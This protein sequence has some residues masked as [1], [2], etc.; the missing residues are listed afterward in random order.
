M[1]GSTHEGFRQITLWFT[2]GFVLGPLQFQSTGQNTHKNSNFVC[3]VLFIWH[4]SHWNSTHLYSNQPT[5]CPVS[6]SSTHPLQNYVFFF[7]PV[8]LQANKVAPKYLQTYSLSFPLEWSQVTQIPASIK[9]GWVYKPEK[10]AFY[11]TFA[12]QCVMIPVTHK[13]SSLLRQALHTQIANHHI[14]RATKSF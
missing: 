4:T 7:F 9:S 2:Y 12:R 6:E 10:L 8:Y 3:A 13:H 14:R 1:Y 11:S 5:L